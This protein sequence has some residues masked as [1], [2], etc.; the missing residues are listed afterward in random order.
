MTAVQK[1]AAFAV[2]LVAVFVIAFWI[3]GIFEPNPDIV[4]PHPATTSEHH[5]AHGDAG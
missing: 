4:V 3:G 2:V 1:I 5:P